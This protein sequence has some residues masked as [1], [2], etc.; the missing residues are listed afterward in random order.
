MSDRIE[1]LEDALQIEADQV[2]ELIECSPEEGTKIEELA[3]EYLEYKQQADLIKG[4]MDELKKILTV[5]G[6]FETSKV[7]VTKTH[8]APSKRMIALSKA[9]N[10]HSEEWLDSNGLTTYGSGSTRLSVKRL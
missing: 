3:L 9:L 7:K 10:S 4:K 6:S 2:T 1:T 8:A 5:N